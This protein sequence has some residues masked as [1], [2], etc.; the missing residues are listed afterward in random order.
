ML[1]QVF[2]LCL[3]KFLDF[4]VRTLLPEAQ[5]E[6]TLH[7][8][9]LP[10]HSLPRGLLVFEKKCTPFKAFEDRC[11]HTLFFDSR[12]SFFLKKMHSRFGGAHTHVRVPYFLPIE[13][14][15]IIALLA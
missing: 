13:F 4:S 8:F 9:M 11:A 3:I 10:P 6:Q 5:K 14:L 2:D 15:R 7:A 1:V 12:N